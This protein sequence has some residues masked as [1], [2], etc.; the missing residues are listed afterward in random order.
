MLQNSSEALPPNAQ[1]VLDG[2]RMYLDDTTLSNEGVYQ[3]RVRN[4]AGQ[5]TKNF[6]LTILGITFVG[7]NNR[8]HVL[9]SIVNYEFE[10]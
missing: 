4:S 3:C 5:S 9:T 7:A 6:A 2:R 8:I 10:L 1:V